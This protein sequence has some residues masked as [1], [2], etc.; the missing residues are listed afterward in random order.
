MLGQLAG[1]RSRHAVRPAPHAAVHANGNGCRRML[2]LQL[3]RE[4]SDDEL[5]VHYQPIYELGSGAIHAVEVLVP[6]RHADERPMGARMVESA[7]RQARV[8]AHD[9]VRP[10]ISVDATPFDLRERGYATRVAAALGT[11]E[12]SPRQLMIEV[13]EA[14]LHDERA[15][16]ALQHLRRIG[17]LLAIDDFGSGD[18]SLAGLRAL[19]VDMLKLDPML[20]AAGPIDPQ[21]AGAVHVIATL[22]R[23]LGMSVIAN[24]IDT[25]P[26]R[27][28]AERAGCRFGQGI[29]LL[30]PVPAAAL[31]DAC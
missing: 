19:P 3:R 12:L 22:G 9:G 15:R 2:T 10:L 20:L 5:T 18:I 30:A 13:D 31:A 24:G 11:Y 14:V 26:Q 1:R 16:P 25:L 6:G 29:H 17:V 21:A 27:A 28:L 4:P 7:A 23:G 8:W